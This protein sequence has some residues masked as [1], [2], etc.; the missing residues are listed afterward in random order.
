MLGGPSAHLATFGYLQGID[1]MEII[2]TVRARGS[3]TISMTAGLELEPPACRFP[4]NQ[5]R[6]AITSPEHSNGEVAKA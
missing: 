1:P 5:P 4:V 6:S 3:T 2:E